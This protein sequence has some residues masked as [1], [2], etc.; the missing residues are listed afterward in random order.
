[1]KTN[2]Y[3][4]LVKFGLT[5]KTL[6]SLNESEISRLHKNLIESKKEVCSKCGKKPCIC[7][8]KKETKEQ[9]S[10]TT[11]TKTYTL[12]DPTQLAK[13]NTEMNAGVAKSM[14]ITPDRS[15]LVLTT[16]KSEDGKEPES[17]G[18]N[19]SKNELKSESAISLSISSHK[20][21]RGL[22]FS[23]LHGHAKEKVSVYA[24]YLNLPLYKENKYPYRKAEFIR[25]HNRIAT[26]ELIKLL[27]TY[28]NG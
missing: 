26:K 1:M 19:K 9:T 10:K 12:T 25:K 17:R 28:K 13:A 23:L 4:D 2:K 5:P 21:I 22:L 27:N 16:G 14:E 3:S 18:K 20:M 15:K 8:N 24:S 7:K 6:M 11:T